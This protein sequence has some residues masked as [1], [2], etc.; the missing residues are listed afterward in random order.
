[1]FRARFLRQYKE[2]AATLC[3]EFNPS[4]KHGLPLEW[5]APCLSKPVTARLEQMRVKAAGA[6]VPP[7]SVWLQITSVT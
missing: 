7:E 4:L 6:R 1:M 2:T 5:V 3:G